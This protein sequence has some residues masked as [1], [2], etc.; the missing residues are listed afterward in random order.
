MSLDMPPCM[1]TKD[2]RFPVREFKTEYA[3]GVYQ[4]ASFNIVYIH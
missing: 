4:M 1:R 2:Y 3:D